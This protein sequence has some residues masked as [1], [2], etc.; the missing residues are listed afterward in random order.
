MIV[1][2]KKV[3]LFLSFFQLSLLGSVSVHAVP[4]GEEEGFSQGIS[5]QPS[6]REIIPEEL[7]LPAI[8]PRTK[9]IFIQGAG[10][11]ETFNARP[12]TIGRD[13]INAIVEHAEMQALTSGTRQSYFLPVIPFDNSFW[14]GQNST[15]ITPQYL[16]SMGDYG[17][18]IAETGGEGTLRML[19][20]AKFLYIVLEAME[21]TQVKTLTGL[22]MDAKAEAALAQ[23][24]TERGG[25]PG[26]ITP[27]QLAAFGDDVKAQILEKSQPA[28]PTPVLRE[29]LINAINKTLPSTKMKLRG[30]KERFVGSFSK[31]NGE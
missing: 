5:R 13:E 10:G 8:A 16:E 26:A 3:I 14:W 2:N 12:L 27:A 1:A 24:V 4:P 9:G 30:L 29:K 15:N 6:L 19:G 31:E 18:L 11:E 7:E 21:D 28:V 17:S 23:F 20:S 22:Q 25:N